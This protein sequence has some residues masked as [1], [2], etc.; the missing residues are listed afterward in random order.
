MFRKQ[1]LYI[2]KPNGAMEN[3]KKHEEQILVS[4]SGIEPITTA[5]EVEVK[6]MFTR[7]TNTHLVLVEL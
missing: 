3:D 6:T 5:R 1:N 4:S 7:P 2:S